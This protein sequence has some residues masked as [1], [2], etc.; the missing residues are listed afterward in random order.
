MIIRAQIGVHFVDESYWIASMLKFARGATPFADEAFVQQPSFFIGAP[1]MRMFLWVTGGSQNGVVL[2]SRSLYLLMSVGVACFVYHCLTLRGWTRRS[3][4]MVAT[5]TIAVVPDGIA[6]LSY[7]NLAAHGLMTALFAGYAVF[8]LPSEAS[9]RRI[10]YLVGCM[11]LALAVGVIA[12]P[13]LCITGGVAVLIVFGLSPPRVRRYLV[14]ALAVT[15]SLSCIFLL[16]VLRN[17]RWEHVE[18]VLALTRATDKLGGLQKLLSMTQYVSRV[19]PPWWLSVVLVAFVSL[20]VCMR[21]RRWARSFALPSALATLSVWFY[22]THIAGSGYQPVLQFV[23][24]AGLLAPFGL[25]LG[26]VEKSL[27]TGLMLSV[28]L[29]SFLASFMFGYSSGNG[30]PNLGLGMLPAL[31]V[32]VACLAGGENRS[33]GGALAKVGLWGLLVFVLVHFQF[34]FVYQDHKWTEQTSWVQEGP[35]A[36]LWT[37]PAKA[38]YLKE[39][40]A[41]VT[42]L[43]RSSDMGKDKIIFYPNFPAGYLMTSLRPGV[44]AS[45]VER[46]EGLPEKYLPVFEAQYRK[47]LVRM[48][49]TN[50]WVVEMKDNWAFGRTPQPVLPTDRFHRLL[51]AWKP[52]RVRETDFAVVYRLP[53]GCAAPGR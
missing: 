28:V 42:D 41:L 1:L 3:A 14:V 11:S 47:S 50:T 31:L 25:A 7:N 18:A 2:Y 23:F 38:D 16:F 37:T 46:S 52:E 34:A 15:G 4:V 45:W 12:Y 10:A 49:N 22:V 24:L 40:S 53:H 32:A 33:P 36:G 20:S 13:P 27:S 35:F 29:P 9:D 17:T 51:A 43:E 48:A 19:L 21:S 44:F 8:G 30:G 39:L 26:L 5:I 6:G